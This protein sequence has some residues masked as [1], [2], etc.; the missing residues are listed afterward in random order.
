[1]CGTIP[2]WTLDGTVATS[3]LASNIITAS[4]NGMSGFSQFAIAKHTT[5][6][7][8]E[9]ALFDAACNGQN[10]ILSWVTATEQNNDYFTLERSCDENFLNYQ[11]IATI[12]GSGNSSTIKEYS[13]TDY[14]AT[15]G[16]CYYRLSQTDLN[17]TKTEFAPISINCKENAAFNFVGVLPNPV[18]DEVNIL[19]TSIN[20]ESVTIT[21][22]DM[23]GQPLLTRTIIPEVGLNKI[24]MST[25]DFSSGVYF[26]NITNGT[27][28]FLKKIVKKG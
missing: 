1:M 27:K 24:K 11:T 28:S 20:S 18:L 12:P 15:A 7:P 8:V 10:T 17:G 4:R 14:D 3:G 13:Y 9:L 21:I 26:I 16:D 25:S 2:S 23:V 19:F 22:T 5:P 6:L